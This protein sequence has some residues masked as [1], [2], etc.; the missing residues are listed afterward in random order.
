M[1]FSLAGLLLAGCSAVGWD[2]ATGFAAKPDVKADAAAGANYAAFVNGT[3]AR[4]SADQKCNRIA[5]ER[6]FDV[7]NQGFDSDMQKTVYDRTYAD[8]LAW[9]VRVEKN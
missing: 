4:P 6:A 3:G 7:G 8:C 1:V 9:A 2:S 5:R